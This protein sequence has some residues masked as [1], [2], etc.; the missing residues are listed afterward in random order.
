MKDSVK[1]LAKNAFGDS[2]E[3]TMENPSCID[4]TKELISTAHSLGFSDMQIFI[5]LMEQSDI[6]A[7]KLRR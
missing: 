7:D 5:A 3:V 6:L 4:L 2:R 1:V